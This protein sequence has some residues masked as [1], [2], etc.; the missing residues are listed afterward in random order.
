MGERARGALYRSPSP[1]LR[2]SVTGFRVPRIDL[3]YS[4]FRGEK[5]SCFTFSRKGGRVYGN[6]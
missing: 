2:A 1:F 4:G 3:P 5:S 6:D